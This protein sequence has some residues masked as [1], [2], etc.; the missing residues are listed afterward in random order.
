MR[1]G[2]SLR[3]TA[4]MTHTI[5]VVDDDR[6]IRSSLRRALTLEGYEVVEAVDGAAGNKVAGD[7]DLMV[8]DATMPKIGGFELC[9]RL[10]AAGSDLP[11]LMLTARQSTSDR[12]EGLDA[13]ADDYLAKPFAL[14]ELLARIRAL[15]RRTASA[16][17]ADGVAAAHEKYE[18]ADLA[19]DTATRE[20]SR[21]GEP[22]ELS[23]TEFA[24]LELLMD[25]PRRVLSSDE[26][27]REVWGYDAALAS[28]SLQV[29]VGYLRRKTEPNDEPRLIHTV[30]G[31]GYVLREDRDKK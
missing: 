10:R 9:R 22:I 17:S 29:Y 26:I 18:F 11:I 3:R 28:N 6:A 24:L 31:V 8:L 1:C 4:E 21:G 25:N 2:V 30:R 15:L 27:Y 7:C 20:V 16:Q 12:V 19:L 5:A 23:R 14:D 13:G